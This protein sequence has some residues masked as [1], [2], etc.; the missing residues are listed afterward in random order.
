MYMYCIYN[1]ICQWMAAACVNIEWWVIESIVHRIT[2]KCWD[3]AK[4]IIR[5]SLF[6]SFFLCAS[7]SL[8]VPVCLYLSVFISISIF[9]SVSRCLSGSQSLYLSVYFCFWLCYCLCHFLCMSICVCL[10]LSPS[11]R[12]SC[13]LAWVV[14]KRT[15]Y[16][17]DWDSVSRSRCFRVE[18][19][20]LIVLFQLLNLNL[21]SNY[22]CA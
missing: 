9:V 5:F 2:H 21:I 7:A 10:R 11:F 19:K 14:K 4:Q 16:L 15:N 12:P 8:I 17:S 1:Y 20:L 13:V 22:V 3:K 18:T 6:L